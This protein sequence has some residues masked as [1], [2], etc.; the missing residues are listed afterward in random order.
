MG[1]L[2]QTLG[3]TNNHCHT[4]PMATN[5]F[6]TK[7]LEELLDLME[8]HRVGSENQEQ[9]KMFII[10]R[11]TEFIADSMDRLRASFEKNA[12]SNDRLAGKVFWLNVV[13]A[14]A[15]ALAALVALLDLYHKLPK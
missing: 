13:I 11:N 2:A 15:T 14:A 6:A 12:D 7:P 3:L 9:L 10:R 5:K 1:R 4:A 8:V